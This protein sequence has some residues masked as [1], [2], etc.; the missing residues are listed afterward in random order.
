MAPYAFGAAAKKISVVAIGC[1]HDQTVTLRRGCGL[2]RV[3][4]G[5]RGGRADS[6]AQEQIDAALVRYYK[7]GRRVVRLKGG[8]PSLF[9][10]LSPEL[11]ALQEAGASVTLVRGITHDMCLVA[12]A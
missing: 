6:A 7:Q 8:C 3:Y 2:Q 10:R 4:M 5:K 1:F 9:G 12:V 11:Q